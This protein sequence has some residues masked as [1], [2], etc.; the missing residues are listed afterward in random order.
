[1]HKQPW[2]RLLCAA[3]CFATSLLG[4]A[5]AQDIT[6]DCGIDALSNQY[7]QDSLLDGD[8]RTVWE[9]G[10]KGRHGLQ[11]YKPE[12]SAT[13]QVLW[14][15]VPQGLQLEASVDGRFEPVQTFAGQ[16]ALPERIPLP[17]AR[18]AYR[19]TADGRV[20]IAE[21][22]VQAGDAP[23]FFSAHSFPSAPTMVSGAPRPD[24]PIRRKD[25]GSDVRALQQR[26]KDLG[27][28]TGRVNGKFEDDTHTALIDFQRASG[29]YANGVFDSATQDVLLAPD[30]RPKPTPAAVTQ[31]PPMPRTAS[32]LI[33]F[34]RG[35]VGMGYVYGGS[36]QISTPEFRGGRA[37]LY[38]DQAELLRGPA[39]EW[40]GMEVYDCV[41]LF[42]AFLQSSEGEYPETWHTTVNG[43]AQRWMAQVGP[44]ET[45]PRLPGV[46]LLQETKPGS[47]RYMHMG[48][49]MG[50]G[51]C[52]HARGHA[53]GV[54]TDAMPQFWTHWAIP[55]WLAFDLPEEAHT[56]WPAYM[57]AGDRALVDTSTTNPLAL[58]TKPEEKIKYRTGLRFANHTEIVIQ[59][60]PKDAPYWRI[61]STVDANGVTRTGYVY[62][63]DLS[64][65]QPMPLPL[66]PAMPT[67]TPVPTPTPILTPVPTA[68]PAPT[69]T[70]TPVPAP[71]ATPIP[72]PTA[73]P[74]LKP[75]ATPTIKPTA[76]PTPRATQT[77]LPTPA[78]TAT[79]KPTQPPMPT[80]TPTPTFT[81]TPT[82]RPTQT[83][84]PQPT[85][86]VTT[87]PTPTAASTPTPKPR[88]TFVPRP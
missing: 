88:M 67:P 56:P 82:P 83:L 11:V 24:R 66:P 17:E 57:G 73:T 74:T 29:L 77:A 49:Y 26:L 6:A 31:A 80:G 28:Y 47:G 35:K 39:R 68:T 53:Y 42:K 22:R 46:L 62:A 75:T 16:D 27:F 85:P 50:E 12:G 32:A 64:L 87:A 18:G 59:A 51:V 8:P 14:G 58:Y 19:L 65:T 54:V 69:P 36:G 43:A 70:A 81:F 20:S 45:M 30:T 72:T 71:T 78:A 61:V 44:I 25:T 10:E 84:P 9:T 21:I 4:G 41:G 3:L 37:R 48:V 5:L 86:Q 38:P 63:K 2:F 52:V 79:V 40:D 55:K 7:R 76:T 60:V 1:M 13:L 34:V 15:L 23:A 33:N